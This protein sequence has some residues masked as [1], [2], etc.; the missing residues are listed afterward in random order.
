MVWASGVSSTIALA[1]ATSGNT[2]NVIQTETG[3]VTP[4]TETILP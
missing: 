1:S 4:L 3:E 2:M